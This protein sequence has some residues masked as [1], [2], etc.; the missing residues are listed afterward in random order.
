VAEVQF[1]QEAGQVAHDYKTLF[2]EVLAE[3]FEVVF[4]DAFDDEEL[5][6]DD[7]EL[8]EVDAEVVLETY[9]PD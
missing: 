5:D 6:D 1:E 4:D 3:T 8:V 9:Y 7:D 2:D